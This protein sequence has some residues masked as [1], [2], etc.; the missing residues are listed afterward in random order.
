[1]R[2]YMQ[3]LF[4]MDMPERRGLEARV[5]WCVL[6]RVLRRSPHARSRVGRLQKPPAARGRPQLHHCRRWR[7]CAQPRSRRRRADTYN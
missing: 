1:M 4:W 7:S 6:W 2:V 3:A 5:L